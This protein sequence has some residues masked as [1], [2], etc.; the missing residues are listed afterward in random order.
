MGVASVQLVV[1]GVASAP[2]TIN[3]E[4][5]PAAQAGVAWRFRTEANYISHRAA[6]GADGTVYVNDSSGFLYALT[7]DGALKWVY[8]ASADGGGSQARP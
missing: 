5:R 3:V 8:D 7:T 4:A 6:V 1:G 2:K